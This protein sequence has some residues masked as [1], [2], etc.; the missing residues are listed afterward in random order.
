MRD[1]AYPDREMVVS[2]V[3]AKH[4]GALGVLLGA[5]VSQETCHLNRVTESA[6]WL[7]RPTS[8]LHPLHRICTCFLGSSSPMAWALV[9]NVALVEGEN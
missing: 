5:T 9:L 1:L 4:S 7:Y 6:D 2:K 3:E 8:E